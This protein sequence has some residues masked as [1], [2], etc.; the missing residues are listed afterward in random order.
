MKILWGKRRRISLVK[1]GGDLSDRDVELRILIL[2]IRIPPWQICE[3]GV[4]DL[5]FVIGPI[6]ICD[7]EFLTRSNY[8]S[9]FICDLFDPY[10]FD[11]VLFEVFLF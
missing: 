8:F 10:Q 2:R 5:E 1:T 6:A 7:F 9:I 11:L 3:C 4:S